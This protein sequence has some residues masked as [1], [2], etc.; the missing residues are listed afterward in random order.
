M[1]RQCPEIPLPA[2]ACS[3]IQQT[4]HDGRPRHEAFFTSDGRAIRVPELLP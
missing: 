4:T 2:A 1:I 3:G